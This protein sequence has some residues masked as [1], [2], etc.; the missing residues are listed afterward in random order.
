VHGAEEVA[1]HGGGSWPAPWSSVCK[2]AEAGT[3][4]ATASNSAKWASARSGRPAWRRGA[5]KAGPSPSRRPRCP[6]RSGCPAWRNSAYRGR[7]ARLLCGGG[8]GGAGREMPPRSPALLKRPPPRCRPRPGVAVIGPGPRAYRPSPR[9]SL[10]LVLAA[11]GT[12]RPRRLEHR[13]KTI[14]TV[15]FPVYTPCRLGADAPGG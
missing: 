11:Q 10:G 1:P 14:Q 9:A 6:S 5:G 2:R 7:H 15:S 12:S 13:S 3:S 8:G 4:R